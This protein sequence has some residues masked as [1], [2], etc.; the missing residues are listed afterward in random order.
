MAEVI[1]VRVPDIGDFAE[2]EVIEIHVANGDS[3]E[4]EESLVTL[5]SDK[6]TMD[7]PSPFAGV[8]KNLKV[9]DWRQSLSGH[10]G[11]LCW[12]PRGRKPAKTRQRPRMK[13]QHPRRLP[14]SH[15]RR[16]DGCRR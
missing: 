7:V 9:A 5:E 3:V 12:K 4:V 10:P 16:L 8:V 2:V 14:R 1:E 11:V 6:A 13:I 15:P